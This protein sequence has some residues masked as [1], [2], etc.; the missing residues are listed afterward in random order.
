MSLLLEKLPVS[1]PKALVRRKKRSERRMQ[2]AYV[3]HKGDELLRL[4]KEERTA[5]RTWNQLDAMTNIVERADAMLKC[6]KVLDGIR[7]RRRI[8]LGEPLP[9]SRRAGSERRLI[10][11][12]QIVDVQPSQVQAEC[13]TPVSDSATPPD[14]LP[15]NTTAE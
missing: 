13:Q 6:H 10:M 15:V 9:G 2:V 11:P 3:T 7:E 4:S 8:L 1:D 14:A 12:M 5:V